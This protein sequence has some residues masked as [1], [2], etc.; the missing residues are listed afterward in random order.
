MAHAI[1]KPND[2]S[3]LLEMKTTPRAA[4]PCSL[5]APPRTLGEPSLRLL[6]AR[7]PGTLRAS[8]QESPSKVGIFPLTNRS[9]TLIVALVTPPPPPL[10]WRRVNH[11]VLP[12]VRALLR[13]S[14]VK[15]PVQDVCST[16]FQRAFP[17]RP[18]Y[19]GF[20]PERLEG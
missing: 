1:R 6:R 11:F 18:E 2:N 17:S 14:R 19:A 9:A 7:S 12:P 4:A 15:A 5:P 3:L 20:G 16:R 13:Y 10:V 8:L